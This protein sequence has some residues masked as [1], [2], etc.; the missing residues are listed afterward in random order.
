MQWSSAVPKVRPPN[1]LH[2]TI[3]PYLWKANV[4]FI[5]LTAPRSRHSSL[6]GLSAS[7]VSPPCHAASFFTSQ[8]VRPC[9]LLV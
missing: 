6:L 3:Q 9:S 5:L 1:L 2:P 8:F 7:L 4:P